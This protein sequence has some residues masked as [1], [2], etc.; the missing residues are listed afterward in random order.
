[1]ALSG[2]Q[3][4][5]RCRE[6]KNKNAELSEIMKQKDRKR[7]RLARLKMTLSEMTALRLRQKINLQKFRAK[8]QNDSDCST[9]QA[10]SFSTKQTKSKALKKIM[11]VLPVNKKRQIELITKVAEDLKILK[12]QKKQE[13]DYQALPTTVKNKV[14]EFYCRDDISYQAPGKRDSITIKENGLRKKMQKKYL[15]FTLR[16]LYELF[17]QENPNAII[18]LSSFQDLRPDYIL[19]KSSIPHNM[20]IC[21]YH[22]NIALLIKSLNKHVQGL[23]TIDLNSFLKLIVCNDQN[24]NCMF[25]NC[26]ICADKFKNEIENKIINPTSLIKWTLWSTSQQGRAV[27]V[28]YEGSVVECVKILSN[29]VEQFLFHVF[30]KRQQSSFFETIKSNTTNKKCLIQVDYSEN[31]AIIEQNEIQSA[32]WSRKQL[33]L[34]TAYVWGNGSTYPLVIVSNNVA[35]NKYTVATC[36]ERILTR[37]QILIP[38]IEELIIFSD[39]SAS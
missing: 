27:K 31:Y 17:I 8:K 35:H 3:R 7:K 25:S 12:I 34:F 20:C 22:E 38:S 32:H 26:S 15:L 19:Y 5:Q 24:Q 11:N 39:G 33:S 4:A 1:M 14:Y 13:R 6:K 9:V 23:D 16:E 36:L 28:D 37:M 10:S 30:I 18:S 21:N 2:A 29:K